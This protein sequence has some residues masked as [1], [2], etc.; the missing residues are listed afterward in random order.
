MAWGRLPGRNR[1]LEILS[2]R[3]L[4][5]G[6][7]EG[8][9]EDGEEVFVVRWRT[10]EEEGGFCGVFLFEFDDVGRIARHVI[11]EVER[12]G[13]TRGEGEGGKGGVV[14]LTE[15]LLKKARGAGA[16]GGGGLAWGCS[17]V[18]GR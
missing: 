5:E 10:C 3:M 17:G 9:G 6:Q 11:E 2:E 12:G 15:W 4:R 16:G 8:E 13:D 7:G 18:R 1:R 14:G